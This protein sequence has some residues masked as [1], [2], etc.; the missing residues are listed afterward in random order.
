VLLEAEELFHRSPFPATVV[1]LGGIYGPERAPWIQGMR[2]GT[3]RRPPQRP[4]RRGPVLN[5]IH[6]DDIVG[7]LIHLMQ[8]P[9]PPSTCIGVDSEPTDG[10]TVLS[11]LARYMGLPEPAAAPEEPEHEGEEGRGKRCRNDSILRL[12]Y[13]FEYPTFREGYAAILRG[14][15][16]QV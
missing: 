6:R 16:V 7:I 11:W 4:S 2:T 9:S 8:L 12:G 14:E 1:R 5:R 10:E 13:R 3:V 15:A